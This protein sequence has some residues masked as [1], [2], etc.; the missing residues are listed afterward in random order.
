MA[1]ASLYAAEIKLSPISVEST[2]ISQVSQ[3]AQTSA[4]LAKALSTEVPSIDMSRRS[5]IAN[6]IYIRGQKRDNIS[7][8]VDGTKV[9]G[10]CPNRMDPPASHILANQIEEVDVT[11]GPY[12]VEN[13]GVL[14]GGVKIKTK[15]PAKGIHGELNA[16]YGAWNYTKVGGTLSAGNDIVRVLVSASTESSD[17]YEDGDGKTLTEQTNTK[18]TASNY[19]SAYLNEPAYT[20]K[21]IMSK[22]FVNVT[23]DQELRLSHTANRSN[24]ILYPNSGMDAT[25]DYSNIYSIGYNVKDISSF[26]K[27]IDLQY[28]YSDVDHPM[29]GKYRDLVMGGKYMVNHLKTSMQGF[30][31]KNNFDINSYKLLVGLDGS[32]RTWEGEWYMVTAATGIAGAAAVSLTH[33]NTENRAVFAKLEKTYGD[34]DLALGTRYDSTKIKPDDTTKRT[35]DYTGANANI[36]ATYHVNKANKI[37]LGFGQASRVPDARELYITSVMGSVAGNENLK[38]VTNQEVDLGY[39]LNNDLMKFKIKGF[40]SILKDY[41]Y[42]NKTTNTFVNLD[43][44]VYGGELSTSIYATDDITLDAGISYKRG[45][46]DNAISGQT[47][48][49][50]ADMA[51]LRGKVGISYE[52]MNNSV[53][54]IE[55]QFSDKWSNYDADAGEQEIAGWGIINMKVKQAINKD[56]TLTVG[57]NNLLDKTYAVSNTYK[58]L[59]LLAVSSGNQMLLNEPGRYLYTN[60]TY[61]F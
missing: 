16:G 28:Y 21:S 12:D 44:K 30:K 25:Y 13:F 22:A 40:Y 42:Y 47:D 36:L 1:V 8:T 57:V 56:F 46:K 26:Y 61:K 35:R 58:D 23:D 55:T 38:Q 6:D 52:Y 14:S 24:N 53:A 11:E 49:D 59:S 37:F 60:L 32:R 17:Q 48:K 41:I 43:A 29:D 33:T 51:P 54:T 3:K 31:L 2:H 5:G 15:K 39:E 7:V 19:T 34:F 27:D 4:D 20:K 10:A 50:L 45:Q 18:S 9:C